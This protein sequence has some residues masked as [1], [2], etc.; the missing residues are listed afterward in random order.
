MSIKK[1][2]YKT[3]YHE[4]TGKYCR[5]VDRNF[6]NNTFTVIFEGSIERVVVAFKELSSLV[7]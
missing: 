6:D 4:A 1:T 5:I 7:Y 2:E 3:A